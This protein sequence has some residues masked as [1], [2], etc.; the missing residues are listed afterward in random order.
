MIFPELF[1]ISKFDYHIFDSLYKKIFSI[2]CCFFF[3]NNGNI[4]FM[5]NI[6]SDAVQTTLKYLKN[7]EANIYNV[8]IMADDFNI[9]NSSYDSLFSFHSIYNNLLMNI[10][11][12]LDLSLSKST[13]QVLISYLD[14][15]QDMNSVINLMFLR[16][17]FLEF[18]NHTIYPE[19][20][21]SSDHA[22]L[23]VDISIIKEFIPNK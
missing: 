22:P 4:Y 12:S 17:N 7:T 9:R 18:D 20:C 1:C 21:Y 23:T 3:F 2:I 11:N 10:A 13:N 19:F 14:N 16:L 5:I 15:V 6:Y 8:L